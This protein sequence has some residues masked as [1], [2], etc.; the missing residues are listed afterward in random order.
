MEEKENMEREQGSQYGQVCHHLICHLPGDSAHYTNT[1]THTQTHIHTNAH[2]RT[3]CQTSLQP[4]SLLTVG[5]IH[6]CVC[7]CVRAGIYIF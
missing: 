5:S 1:D 3:Q 2:A 6:A 7:L 4:A